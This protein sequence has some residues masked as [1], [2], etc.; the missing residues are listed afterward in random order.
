MPPKRKV[1]AEGAEETNGAFRWT[2]ENE[3]KLL[4]LIQNRTLAAEDYDR[5]LTAFPGTNLNGVKIKC[6]R[7]RVEQR[8]TYEELGWQLPEGG[9]GAKRKKDEPDTPVKKPRAKKETKAK[10]SEDDGEGVK[11]EP[12]T[13]VK[14]PRAKKAAKA[15]ESEDDGEG[16]GVGVKEE[17]IEDKA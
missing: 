14:K 3:R 13:P 1:A 2:L 4:I 12:E 6:S 8:N 9:A 10:E 5:L 16:V 11:D 7:F 15:K 17:N